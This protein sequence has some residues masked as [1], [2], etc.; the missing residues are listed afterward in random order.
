MDG[1]IG[2]VCLLAFRF[3]L[4]QKASPIWK[5]LKN[6]QMGHSFMIRP[7]QTLVHLRHSPLLQ[8]RKGR[9]LNRLEHKV[10][11]YA[12]YDSMDGWIIIIIIIIKKVKIIVTL[13][14][15]NTAGALYKVPLQW[16]GGLVRYVCLLA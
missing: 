16:M 6:Y 4:E 14:I 13:S 7:S 15:K 2:Q 12:W 11:T 3:L 1:W 5:S 9:S 8:L 10:S